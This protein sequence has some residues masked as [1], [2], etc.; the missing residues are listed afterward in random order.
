[1]PL[2]VT[3]GLETTFRFLEHLTFELHLRLETTFGFK[4]TLLEA[5]MWERLSSRDLL[6]CIANLLL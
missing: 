6:S 4:N 1:L 5:P 3:C 2:N